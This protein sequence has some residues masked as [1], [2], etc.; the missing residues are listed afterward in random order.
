M[1]TQTEEKRKE[2][3]KKEIERIKKVFFI[4]KKDLK[5]FDLKVFGIWELTFKGYSIEDLSLMFNI[6]R[7]LVFDI[8]A[9]LNNKLNEKEIIINLK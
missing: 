1:K 5:N 7:N 6:R 9:C 8:I 4:S 3:I 2:I